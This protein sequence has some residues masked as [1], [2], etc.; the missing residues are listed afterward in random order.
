[1]LIKIQTIVNNHVLQKLQQLPL[2]STRLA[3]S[4]LQIFYGYSMDTLSSN[5]ELWHMR[6]FVKRKTFIYRHS[7]IYNVRYTSST[8]LY[9]C[10]MQRKVG[11]DTLGYIIPLHWA[12][13]KYVS[14]LQFT[15]YIS[16]SLYEFTIWKMPLTAAYYSPSFKPPPLPSPLL[17]SPPLASPPHPNLS[18][19]R[20]W[21]NYMTSVHLSWNTHQ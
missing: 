5:T 6:Q 8:L 16:K 14:W 10:L 20:C 11:F 9:L 2:S 21:G 13:L 4:T 3:R 15:F 19:Q 17:P 1:M 12:T 7:Y 18:C